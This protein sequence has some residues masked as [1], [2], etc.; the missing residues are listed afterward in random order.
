MSFLATVSNI[1]RTA[2][3]VLSALAGSSSPAQERSAVPTIEEVNASQWPGTQ[4][5]ISI[6]VDR[7]HPGHIVAASMNLPDGRILT[8]ASS[9]GGHSYRRTTIPLTP[10]AQIHADPMVAFDSRG[11]AFLAHIPVGVGNTPLGI[12]VTRSLD[13]GANWLPSVSVSRA[14]GRDDKVILA[15]DDNPESPYR[16]RVYV[17]WKWPSGGAFIAYSRDH[18]QT[19][20]RPRLASLGRLSGLDMATASDGTLYLAFHDESASAIRIVR[21]TDGGATFDPPADVSSVRTDWY[22]QTPSIC[23]RMALVHASIAVDRSPSTHRGDLHATWTDIPEGVDRAQCLDPCDPNSPCSASVYAA[24]STDGGATW[25]SPLAVHESGI[26][27]DRYHQWLESDPRDGALYVAYKDT[28]HDSS[29]LGT[30]VYLS[31]SSDCGLS[32]EP[33]VRV[34]GASSFADRNDF[35]YGDYQGLA[36]NDG[37]VFPAWADFRGTDPDGT[38][39]AEA[40]VGRIHYGTTSGAWS[41]SR[42]TADSFQLTYRGNASEPTLVD[43]YLS[44]AAPDKHGRLYVTRGGDTSPRVEAFQTDAIDGAVALTVA[45]PR[46]VLER[47][48]GSVLSAV[49]APV[50][51]AQRGMT[52]FPEARLVVADILQKTIL[53]CR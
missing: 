14:T 1:R 30:D 29:R 15:A 7:F 6:A 41:A 2:L 23:T 18:G 45:V 40:Y 31:R 36:V 28:R 38:L 37:A 53:G 3:L 50:D 34:T 21:S 44:L 11:V 43:I 47:E 51:E 5:E 27:A 13:G 33:S 22:T 4:S 42:R 24:R 48:P 10:G 32:W 46:H 12:E 19:F 8:M 35:Q 20:T 52:S 17:A 16:D 39:H 25:S 26:R 9:D 49:I